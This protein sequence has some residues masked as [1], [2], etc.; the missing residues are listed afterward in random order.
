MSYFTPRLKPPHSSE[1]KLHDPLFWLHDLPR[2]L[3]GSRPR[4][5]TQS[6]FE[7]DSHQ[8]ARPSSPLDTHAAD[9][10]PAISN[11]QTHLEPNRQHLQTERNP[12]VNPPNPATTSSNSNKRPRPAR[13]SDD[14]QKSNQT[15]LEEGNFRIQE[16]ADGNV[17][18][19]LAQLNLSGCC[20]VAMTVIDNSLSSPF[21]IFGRATAEFDNLIGFVLGIAMDH[22]D[23]SEFVALIMPPD[24]CVHFIYKLLGSQVPVCMWNVMEVLRQCEKQTKYRNNVDWSLRHC[25]CLSAAI[26]LVDPAADC[27]DFESCIAFIKNST[28]LQPPVV[29]SETLAVPSD[30]HSRVQFLQSCLRCCVQLS[31]HVMLELERLGMVHVFRSIEM[32]LIG[33]TLAMERFG[34]GFAPST[35]EDHRRALSQRCQE[36]ISEANAAAGTSF[37]LSSPQQLAEVL[38]VTLKL[39]VV[40][41]R[42]ED[43]IDSRSK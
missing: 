11:A 7:I 34:I 41:Q 12:N 27:T 38:F 14:V 13:D 32:P 17:D 29:P 28:Q 24:C 19:F 1:F 26:W 35:L 40:N 33:I 3:S 6:T 10:P 2:I 8:L 39:P 36:L 21:N 43:R 20:H 23:I 18:G 25:I 30:K 42:V 4:I 5:P 9:S 22:Q 15:L 37:L 16:C 31:K